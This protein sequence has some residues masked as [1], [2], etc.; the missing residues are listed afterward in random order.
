MQGSSGWLPVT[1]L[2]AVQGVEWQS[3]PCKLRWSRDQTHHMPGFDAAAH[4]ADVFIVH[5]DVV[6]LSGL[7]F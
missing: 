4:S 7:C 1:Y 5:A 3:L 2:G 6:M